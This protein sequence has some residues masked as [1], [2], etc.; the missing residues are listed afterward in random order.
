MY[1][2]LGTWSQ[3]LGVFGK[4]IKGVV[5]GKVVVRVIHGVVVVRFKESGN[6]YVRISC[7]KLRNPLLLCISKNLQTIYL[8]LSFS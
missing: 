1:L 5:V 6:R 7:K 4:L 3:L 2:K 8:E